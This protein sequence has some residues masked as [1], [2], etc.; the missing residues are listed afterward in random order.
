M[1]KGYIARKIESAKNICKIAT[2][3]TLV[4]GVL[5]IGGSAY[6]NT[7]V[8]ADNAKAPAGPDASKREVG[9]N[10]YG[11]AKVAD[12]KESKTIENIVERDAPAVRDAA[13]CAA[14]RVRNEAIRGRLVAARDAGSGA[15]ESLESS[16]ASYIKIREGYSETPYPD[17]D[18]ISTGYGHQ[19]LPRELESLAGAGKDDHEAILHEDIGKAMSSIKRNVD[20]DLNNNQYTAL[21]DFIYNAGS[22][23]FAGS[24]LLKKLNKS[25]YVGASKE[26]DRWVNSQTKQKDGTFKKMINPVLVERRNEE[27]ALFNTASDSIAYSPVVENKGT[28]LILK[29][30]TFTNRSTIGKMY[31]DV[32][33]NGVID[34]KDILIA[35][36]LELPSNDNKVCK[37][38]IP[39]GVYDV[40]SRNSPKFK[41]HFSL[42]EVHGRTNIL[43]HTGNYPK[44]TTGCILVGKTRG[45]DAI[46]SSRVTM[47]K[48]NQR[49]KGKKI[50][51]KITR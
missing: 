38:S 12:E 26:F 20:V 39:V 10:F 37:S 3:A 25:D 41:Q 4:G 49:F 46:N 7:G 18:K 42:T 48:L 23:A 14:E 19:L 16:L 1:E 11:E 21:I 28:D 51:L 34:S 2:Y 29:R 17:A 8:F 5:V 9:D 31:E 40:V 44:N 47:N 36:T 13:Y 43:I 22:G 30:D 15:T 33:H 27:E 50:R 24:T 35:E 32:N 45:K 6:L